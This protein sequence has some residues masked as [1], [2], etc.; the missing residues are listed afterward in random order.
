MPLQ[1]HQLALAG[2]ALPALASWLLRQPGD[3]DLAGGLVILPSSRA[4]A[5]LRHALLDASGRE[6]L[7][8]PT[9]T[10]PRATRRLAGR[11]VRPRRG[12]PPAREPAAA[13]ARAAPRG[14]RLAGRAARG[15]DRAGRG[16]GGALRRGPLGRPRSPGARRRRTTTRLLSFGAPE[17]AEIRARRPRRACAS[18]GGL[19]RRSCRSTRSTGAWRRWRRRWPGPRAGVGG[20]GAPRPPRARV[21]RLAPRAAPRRACRRTW[22]R[23]TRGTRAR[24]C[25][26]RPTATRPPTRIRWRARGGLAR[27]LAGA[28]RCRSR[29]FAADTV[30]G[31]LAELDT[32]RPG[33][34]A[35]SSCGPATIRS[36]R[37]A[38]SRA[39]CAR[40]LAAAGDGAG[41]RDHRRHARPRASR[42]ASS[43]QLRD[44]GVDVDDT[45]GR[46]L[47]A[48]PAGRLLRDVLR[49]V[50]T[51]LALRPALRGADPPLRGPRAGRAARARRARARCSRARCA[52]P[53]R[54]AAGARR[55]RRSPPSPTTANARGAAAPRS[56]GRWPRSWP[57]VAAALAPLDALGGRPVGWDDVIARDP[58]GL[59]A[60][61]RPRVR[62]EPAP[63]RS[64]EFDDL[65]ALAGLLDALDDAASR[66]AAAARAAR[67]PASSRACCRPRPG[68]R[69]RTA[70]CTCP[71]ASWAWS[72]RASSSA[73]LVILAGLGQ[74]TFPGQDPASPVP[75]R[76][77]APRPRPRRTGASA[78]A[79]TASCSCACCTRRRAW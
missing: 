2:G 37:A 21:R 69:D 62:C 58:R 64:G 9:I 14:H 73:D 50:Q 44:A 27:R 55:W 67:S 52:R 46:A 51:G 59:G 33:A 41:A 61:S 30:A 20:R 47:A 13:A 45:R 28:G 43:P 8:L 3:E 40:Q 42:R 72:R 74:E 68:R 12:R 79:A 65:G 19:P 49:V 5:A 35:T 66:L 77:A 75:G 31:R 63:I 11:P 38:W 48:L 54:R 71:C 34:R 32:R 15:G 6:A 24:A 56:A 36:R 29:S 18:P 17:A 57:T 10:T 60:A 23:S 4:A 7:L 76:P 22:C 39:A 16:T 25:C 70:R 53:R 78:R 1:H 26:W